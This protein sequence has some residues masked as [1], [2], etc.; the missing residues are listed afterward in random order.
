MKETIVIIDLDTEDKWYIKNEC[1]CPNQVIKSIYC[2]VVDLNASVSMG[3]YVGY[4]NR[5]DKE[6]K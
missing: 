3:V 1:E 5:F 4:P 2:S 6:K